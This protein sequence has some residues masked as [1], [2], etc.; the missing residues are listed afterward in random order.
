MVLQIAVLCAALSRHGCAQLCA[1]PW[2]AVCQAPLSTGFSRQAG[3]SGLPCPPPGGLP[4]RGRTWVSCLS[5]WQMGSFP[6]VPLGKPEGF[7]LIS[8]LSIS[9]LTIRTLGASF[10]NMVSYLSQPLVRN[11]A[12]TLTSTPRSLRCPPYPFTWDCSTTLS[13]HWWN[14]P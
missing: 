2:T 12:P 9:F 14:L 5:H 11:R 10:L 4:T 13:S 3:C 6:L 7:T 1:T 8:S